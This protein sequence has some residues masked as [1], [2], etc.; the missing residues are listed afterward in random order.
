MEQFSGAIRELLSYLHGADPSLVV[1][2][3]MSLLVV[4]VVWSWHRNKDNNFHLQQVLVDNTSGKI[5][6]EKVGFMTALAISTWGFV[7]LILRDKI[8]EWYVGLYIMAFVAGRFG[9][10]WLSV[11]KE[12]S[13][14]ANPAP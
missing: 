12:L 6:I 1:L 10:S 2:V 13:N 4:S 14:A 5:S 8:N 3:V 11:K 7:A 9:S